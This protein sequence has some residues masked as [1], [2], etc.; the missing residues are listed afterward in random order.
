MPLIEAM[1]EP[2]ALLSRLRSVGG[3]MN[4]YN[5]LYSFISV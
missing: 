1:Y 5:I 4:E 3:L 2:I